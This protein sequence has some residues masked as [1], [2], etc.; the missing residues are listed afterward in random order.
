ML[1]PGDTAPD[2]TLPDQ[3]GEPVTLSAFQG[4]PVVLV[5]YPKA[6]TPGCTTQVCGVRDHRADYATADAVVLGV[7][8]D[9]VES[10]AAWDAEHGLGFPLLSDP[11]HAV[12]EAYGAWQEKSMYGNTYMGVQ[13]STVIVGPDGTVAQVIPRVTPKTHDRKVL[14]ALS[15][16]RA[17][18]ASEA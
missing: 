5:F 4:R 16:L 9:P 17:G 10:L 1:E 2:F 3:R 13:R 15:A 14:E 6:A 8:R 12:T 11:D 7:S 18:S